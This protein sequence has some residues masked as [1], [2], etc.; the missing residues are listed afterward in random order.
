MRFPHTFRLLCNL[1]YE[2]RDWEEKEEKKKKETPAISPKELGLPACRQEAL[3]NARR[4]SGTSGGAK[5]RG[6]AGSGRQS[7][8]GPR[9]PGGPGPG[10]S[11][12]GCGTSTLAASHSPGSSCRSRERCHRCG[13]RVPSQP[14]TPGP[15]YKEPLYEGREV[16]PSEP[17][18]EPRD[19]SDTDLP[20]TA[21][22]IKM[23]VYWKH[24]EYL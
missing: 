5:L 10:F 18:A 20:L 23:P 4:E 15:R 24:M 6:G 1:S 8:E 14:Q 17:P 9:G 11:P 12:S 16:I 21:P 13:R 19:K 22:V 7:P 3:K 2:I